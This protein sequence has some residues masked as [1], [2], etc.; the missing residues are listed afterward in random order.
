MPNET[1][2]TPIAIALQRC[3]L[4][5]ERLTYLEREVEMTRISLREAWRDVPAL[6]VRDLRPCRKCRKPTTDTMGHL[7]MCVEHSGDMRTV[8]EALMGDSE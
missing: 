4:L 2:S 7:P 5:S 3:R 6:P 8:Y 1:P